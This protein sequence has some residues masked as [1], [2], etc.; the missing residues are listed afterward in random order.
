MLGAAIIVF[1]E[2]LEAALLISIVAAATRSLSHRTRW[3]VFGL[4]A[5]ILGS[6]VVAGFMDKIA[7]LADGIGQDIFNALVLGAAVLMLGW[8]NVWMARHGAQMASEARSVAKS[9]QEGRRELSAIALVIALAVLRE[10]SETALFLFGLASGSDLAMPAILSGG[11]LGMG[12]GAGLGYAMYRGLLRI[13]LRHLFSVTSVLILLLAAGMAGQSARFLI[14][15]DLLSGMVTPLWDTS[16]ILPVNSPVGSFL[17][18]LIGYDARP[19]ATQVIFYAA[20]AV[21]ILVGM[22]WA[23]PRRAPTPA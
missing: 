7:Q 20:V 12:A 6:L 22:R 8:H 15:A 1:R 10:G 19:S 14:Q 2:T 5:G 4:L 9:V 13:P 11:A 21:S 3:L 16:H 18:V 23:R 17:H